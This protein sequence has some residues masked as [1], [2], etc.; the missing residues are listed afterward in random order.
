MAADVLPA[1]LLVGLGVRELSMNPAAIPRVK[2]AVRA[3]RVD[4]LT[5]L[6]RGCLDLPTAE[7]IEATL[8]RAL[9]EMLAPAPVSWTS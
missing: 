7:E 5:A 6:A 2:A 8:R 3:V 1:L 9:A 4:E